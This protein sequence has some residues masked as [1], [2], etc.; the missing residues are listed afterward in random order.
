MPRKVLPVV[1]KTEEVKALLRAQG[2]HKI[3]DRQ[4]PPWEQSLLLSFSLLR[5]RKGGS[6]RIASTL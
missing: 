1:W 6:A 2:K 4:T 3:K 5:R